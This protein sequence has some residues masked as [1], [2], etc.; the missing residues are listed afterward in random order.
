MSWEVDPRHVSENV[1]ELRF[2][3]EKGCTTPANDKIIY[4]PLEG[5]TVLESDEAKRYSLLVAKLKSR[6][7]R[8]TG[9]TDIQCVT[10]GSVQFFFQFFMFAA[11]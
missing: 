9:L 10:Q 1:V 4:G 3:G 6:V 8:E 7:T 5:E 11:I 2:E